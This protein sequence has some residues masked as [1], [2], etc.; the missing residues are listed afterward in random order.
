LVGTTGDVL[1]V[2]AAHPTQKSRIA[3]FD[4]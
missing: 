3:A 1:A 2:S 4:P